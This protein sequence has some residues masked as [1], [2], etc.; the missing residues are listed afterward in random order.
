MAEA[1][2]GYEVPKI[3]ADLITYA[4]SRGWEH[5]VDWTQPKREAPLL[6]VQVGRRMVKKD[7]RRYG[8]FW[9]YKIT[10]HTE[11]DPPGTVRKRHTG[12]CVTPDEP[13]WHEAPPLWSIRETIYTHPTPGT[14]TTFK[15]AITK[16]EFN[17]I[18]CAR[19]LRFSHD[20]MGLRYTEWVGGDSRTGWALMNDY[21]K[22][23]H[24]CHVSRADSR[25]MAAE[26]LTALLAPTRAFGGDN[27]TVDEWEIGPYPMP[28][29]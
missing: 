26:R 14:V 16:E 23:E 7:G 19:A 4:E 3:V 12:L 27:L 8:T 13:E 11:G 18:P 20:W 21:G 17:A 24:P 10:Y 2:D 28:G 6:T 9:L 1:P 25:A 29:T 5:R 15:G 22:P